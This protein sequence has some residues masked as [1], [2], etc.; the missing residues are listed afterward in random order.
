M[1]KRKPPQPPTPTPTPTGPVAPP[2]QYVV[3]IEPLPLGYPPYCRR[4]TLLLDGQMMARFETIVGV[5]DDIQQRMQ[6]T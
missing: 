4:V 6:R 5:A 1:S 3:H 2:R